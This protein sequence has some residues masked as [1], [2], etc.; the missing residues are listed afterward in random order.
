MNY[1][2]THQYTIL[3]GS[4]MKIAILGD[5]HFICPNDPA[6]T[7]IPRSC[8][9]NTEWHF[10]KQKK[11]IQDEQTDLIILL[12]D[13]V[14]WYSDLNRD[15]GIALIDSIG[16]PWKMVAGNHDFQ[17]YPDLSPQ[18]PIHTT[19]RETREVCTQGWLDKGIELHD[20]IIKADNTT[21]ILMETGPSI[22]LPGARPW[23]E[24]VLKT[25][26]HFTLITHVPLDIPQMREYILK[27][28]PGR[29]LKKYVCSRSPWIYDV[30]KGQVEHVF[31]GHL[32]FPGEL[33]IDG[34]HMHLLPLGCFMTG[35][36]YE[37]M[38][39]VTFFDTKTFA[40][41]AVIP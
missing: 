29:D 13:L 35:M 33:Q 37:A 23:L 30:I 15:Y 17:I 25:G 34:T 41:T 27:K 9:Q 22:A 3:H 4:F 32:H 40:I 1:D 20:R 5:P 39:Q 24:D 16:I 6:A 28:S 10:E 31:T 18:T 12:G 11:L 8:F 36:T 2:G 7:K 19:P 21:L 38:G 14:D 26:G